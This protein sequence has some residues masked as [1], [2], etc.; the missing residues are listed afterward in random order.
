[1]TGKDPCGLRLDNGPL[2]GYMMRLIAAYL[3]KLF[4]VV[5]GRWQ[6]LQ[7][8]GL[9]SRISKIRKNLSYLGALGLGGSRNSD[10]S[11]SQNTIINT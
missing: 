10:L 4:W 1:M 2:V 9:Y 3:Y 11:I 7:E 5:G 8:C 6:T